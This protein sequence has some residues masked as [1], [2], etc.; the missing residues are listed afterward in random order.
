VASTEAK[1]ASTEAKVA[2]TEAK[3]ASAESKVMRTLGS[4]AEWGKVGPLD[5]ALFYLQ[6][7]E[8]HFAALAKVSERVEIAKDLLNRVAEFE[9]GARTLRN[10]VDRQALAEY[11]LP[12]YPLS[13]SGFLVSA[14]ELAYVNDYLAAAARIAG[15]AEG[16]RVELNKII[17]GWDAVLVQAKETN[18]F[19][20]KSAWE[21]VTELDLRFSKTGAGFRPFLVE[22]RDKAGR[23]AAFAQMKRYHASHIL[24]KGWVP[25]WYTPPATAE[26]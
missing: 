24:G 12:N 18:D 17:D 16:A 6:F 8:G 2:S 20:R 13:A 1:V 7:H 10:A 5:F 25:D 15:D 4:V 23:V 26:H 19:T 9:S 21:A 14:D 11:E 22:T 3:V